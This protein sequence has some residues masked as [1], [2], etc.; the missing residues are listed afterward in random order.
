MKPVKSISLCV[1]VCNVI[2]TFKEKEVMNL[3]ENKKIGIWVG[4]E[5]GKGMGMM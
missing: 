4:L 1:R 5:E 2:L 3:R